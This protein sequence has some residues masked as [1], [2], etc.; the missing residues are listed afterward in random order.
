MTDT[1]RLDWAEA[2]PLAFLTLVIGDCPDGTDALRVFAPLT[3]QKLPTGALEIGSARW[4]MREAIDTAALKTPN[5][6]VTG[7]SVSEGPVD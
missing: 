3:G 1:E 7:L 6:Q 2:N 4:R 5:A